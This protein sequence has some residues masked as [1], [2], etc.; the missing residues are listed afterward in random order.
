MLK[1]NKKGYTYLKKWKIEGVLIVLSAV[2]IIAIAIIG[3]VIQ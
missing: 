1:T 2:M 3:W